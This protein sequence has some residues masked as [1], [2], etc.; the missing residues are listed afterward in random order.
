MYNACQVLHK[1]L[2]YRKLFGKSF[3]FFMHGFFDLFVVLVFEDLDHELGNAFAFTLFESAGGDRGC[4]EPNTGGIKR[5]SSIICDRIHIERN[6]YFI[7]YG[8]RFL[9]GYPE[10]S[11]YV[12]KDEVVIRPTTNHP[13]FMLFENF[14]HRF[15]IFENLFRVD[16]V[17]WSH[18]F[19]ECYSLC[20]NNMHMWTPLNTRE[21]R[22][23][24]FLCNFFTLAS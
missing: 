7:E 12:R 13:N 18:C 20:R 8:L 24:D 14:G 3:N 21:N 15:C 19:A 5:F 10:G 11:E 17:L 16:F 2:W 23:V 4:T 6:A 9:A 1:A 22:F